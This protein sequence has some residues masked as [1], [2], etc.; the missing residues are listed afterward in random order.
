MWT[1]KS[2]AEAVGKLDI[3][4]GDLWKDYCTD[5]K[6]GD[7]DDDVW[8]LWMQYCILFGK[9]FT[10]GSFSEFDAFRELIEKFLATGNENLQLFITT[11]FL[12]G[13]VNMLDKQSPEKKKVLSLFGPRARS[14]INAYNEYTGFD[15]RY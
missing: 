2:S 13:I 10:N 9:Q 14:Y 1:L 12:E 11:V 5:R 8:D 4:Y 7:D 6:D 3:N 15:S